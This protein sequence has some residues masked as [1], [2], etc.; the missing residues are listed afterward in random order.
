MYPQNLQRWFTRFITRN[1]LPPL[2]LHGL[3][4]T[5]TALLV[6]MSEDIAQISRRL[7]HS[8]ITTTLNT[9]THLFKSSDKTL[10]AEMSKRLFAKDGQDDDTKADND[11]DCEE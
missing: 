8:E 9:Y 11:D 6:S 10:T 1:D 2:T 5:H 3:R 4:H 7:G